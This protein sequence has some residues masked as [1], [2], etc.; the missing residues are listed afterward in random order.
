MTCRPPRPRRQPAWLL[1]LALLLTAASCGPAREAPDIVRFGAGSTA[2]QQLLV[3]L[4]AE[5]LVRTDVAAEVISGLGDTDAVRDAALGGRIDAYWDYSGAAWT[6]ALGLSAPAVDAQESFE[7][8]AAEE[9]DNGLRWLGPSGVDAALTFFIAK[10][11]QPA[12]QEANLS[13]LAGQLGARDG[14]LCADAGYL[15]APAGYGYLADTYAISTDTVTTVAAVEQEAITAVAEGGCLAGL[16]TATSG[17]ARSRG[18]VPLDDD[19]DVFPAF[20][21]APV[22]V[23]DGPADRPEVAAALQRLAEALDTETLAA[24]NARVVEGGAIDEVAAGY[25][26]EAGLG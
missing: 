14:A 25:L 13:W 1:V 7:A 18:L 23:E 8:V 15:T 19:Q 20:V 12:D 22:V 2:E 4:S 3:A 16:A 11:D 10:G 9:A 5:L 24:L 26:D 17:A 6:L 21:A